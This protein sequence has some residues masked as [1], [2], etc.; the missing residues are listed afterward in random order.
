LL[1]IRCCYCLKLPHGIISRKHL[2]CGCSIV[3]TDW[4]LDTFQPAPSVQ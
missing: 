4:D 2:V 3:Q 1:S